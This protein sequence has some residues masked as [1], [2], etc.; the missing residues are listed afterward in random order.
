MAVTGRCS[1]C[2]RSASA[3]KTRK[4]GAMTSSPERRPAID[5]LP[6]AL[7]SMW[8]LCKLGYRHEPALIL[9]AFTLALLASLP[10][11]L[12]ALWFMLLGEG[13]LESDWAQVRIAVV[14]LGLSATATWFLVTV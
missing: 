12:V 14:A 9:V 2:R 8:R 4:A 1:T 13:V 3:A 10:D 5:P 7:S 6:P 11:A